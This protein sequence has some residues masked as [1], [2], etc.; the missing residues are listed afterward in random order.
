MGRITLFALAC[1]VLTGVL[2]LALDGALEARADAAEAPAY[3]VIVNARSPVGELERRFVED[4]FLKKVVLWPNGE[5]IHPVD[6]VAD[7][8]VRRAFTREVLNRSVEA[9][10]GYWQQRIFSGRD[11]PPPEL[12]HDEDVVQYVSAHEGGIGY[13]SG[14]AHVDGC[15]VILVR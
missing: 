8:A 7:S 11:V 6:L 1:A 5:R 4:A 15:R 13:V 10:K 9:V 14:T 12:P 3:V 2:L